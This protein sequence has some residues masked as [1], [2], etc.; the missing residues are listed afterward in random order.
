MTYVYFIYQVTVPSILKQ[1]TKFYDDS[2]LDQQISGYNSLNPK[3]GGSTFLQ[4]V[5]TNIQTYT[6]SKPESII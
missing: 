1:I 3:D 4:H 5:L 2:L 6:V